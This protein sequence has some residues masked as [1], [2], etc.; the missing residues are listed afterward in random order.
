MFSYTTKHP[1]YPH[2]I[3]VD[4]G[5]VDAAGALLSIQRFIGR[6]NKRLMEVRHRVRVLRS[7]PAL[8]LVRVPR[9]P[10]DLTFHAPAPPAQ[11]GKLSTRK[12]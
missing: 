5:A 10:G 8:A 7:D 3:T 9:A 6:E 11:A 2:P 4:S 12:R 1:S